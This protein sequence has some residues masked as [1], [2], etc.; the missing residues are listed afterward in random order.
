M[1]RWTA[2]KSKELVKAS[3][4]GIMRSYHNQ[5]LQTEMRAKFARFIAIMCECCIK[6]VHCSE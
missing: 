5:E 2:T 6:V 1:I 4:A 3:A